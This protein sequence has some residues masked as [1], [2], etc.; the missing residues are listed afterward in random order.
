MKNGQKQY[1]NIDAD[2]VKFEDGVSFQ[3]KLAAGILK[4]EKGD[5]GDKGDKGTDGANGTNGTNGT[6]GVSPTVSVTKSGTTATISI[7]DKNGAHSTTI[8]DGATGATGPQGPSGSDA[9]VT[10]TN[11]INALGY[12]PSN[13][14]LTQAEVEQMINNNK[15]KNISVVKLP[16]ISEQY[17]ST[18]YDPPSDSVGISTFLIGSGFSND[19]EYHDMDGTVH[20]PNAAS[21]EELGAYFAGLTVHTD[22]P[23][24]GF[25]LGAHKSGLYI[26]FK[27]ADDYTTYNK[28][29]NNNLPTSWIQIINRYGVVNNANSIILMEYYSGYVAS[30]YKN[31]N[32]SGFRKGL[33]TFVISVDSILYFALLFNFGNTQPHAKFGYTA[34]NS[35]EGKGTLFLIPHDLSST[36]KIWAL[37]LQNGKPTAYKYWNSN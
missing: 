3:E 37:K 14:G 17:G 36:A 9:M 34:Y 10:R 35:N 13:S 19:I 20:T 5:K 30:N 23:K 16:F 8:N 2:D 1:V 7:T 12:T 27:G 32:F 11:V 28:T 26:R 15:K 21:N 4:G 33:S 18:D 29:V 24:V 22:E 6:D 31:W 25:H